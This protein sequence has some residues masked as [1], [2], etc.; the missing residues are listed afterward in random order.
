LKSVTTQTFEARR[1][2]GDFAPAYARYTAY[3]GNNFLSN[4]WR[5]SSEANVHDALLRTGEAFIGRLVA[6][7][8]AEFGPDLQE[9]IFYR[10][11]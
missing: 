3:A 11:K 8:F 5:V 2:D 6:D 7:A 10:N 4:E 1:R 9:R